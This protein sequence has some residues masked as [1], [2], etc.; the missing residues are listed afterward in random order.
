PGEGPT[1]SPTP[2]PTRDRETRRF[3]VIALALG[4]LGVVGGGLLIWLLALG[5]EGSPQGHSPQGSDTVTPKNGEPPA[6][7]SPSAPPGAPAVTW[8]ARPSARH[9]AG[10]WLLANKPV[11]RNHR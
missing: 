8:S 1:P 10:A 5:R 7:A 3:R 11:R 2:A 6:K 9:Q 4:L